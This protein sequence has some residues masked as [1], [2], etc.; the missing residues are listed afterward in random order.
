MHTQTEEN[1]QEEKTGKGGKGAEGKAGEEGS[2]EKGGSAGR[3]AEIR[4]SGG[5]KTGMHT[6][7]DDFLNS[8]PHIRQCQ[9]SAPQLAHL[10]L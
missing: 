4:Q 8:R 6:E 9:D 3:T 5:D 7:L 10:V 1:G 2:E